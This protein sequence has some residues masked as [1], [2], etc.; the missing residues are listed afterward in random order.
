M[1][2]HEQQQQQ[3]QSQEQE[4][5]QEQAQEPSQEPQSHEQPASAQ[6]TAR[7]PVNEPASAQATAR[8]PVNEPAQETAAKAPEWNRTG[9]D[10]RRPWPRPPVP[11]PAIDFHVHLLAG[12]HVPLAT[13]PLRSKPSSTYIPS[14]GT[15]AETRA[16]SRLDHQ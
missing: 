3:Q 6:A 15:P 13:L 16:R 9:V 5:A 11:A 2:E 4:R 7:E 8:E 10:L 12:R 14:C 1:S